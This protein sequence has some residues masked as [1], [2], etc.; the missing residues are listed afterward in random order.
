VN[1]LPQ[2]NSDSASTV[3]DIPVT[4]PDVLANDDQGDAP[5]TITDFDSTS[6]QWRLSDQ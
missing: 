1:A 6:R 2:A 3:V 4:T 5:A